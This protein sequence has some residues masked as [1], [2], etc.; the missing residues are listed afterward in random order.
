MS[1]RK[2]FL[3]LLALIAL[4]TPLAPLQTR[5][6][7]RRAAQPAV[8]VTPDSHRELLSTYCYTCHSSR[9]KSGGLALDSFDLQKAPENAEVW[10]KA[11][12]KLRGRLMPPPGNP[13]PPQKDIDAFITWMESTLDSGARGPWAGY[14]PI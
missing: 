13:Q 3:C 2:G 12:R 14:V 9:M 11:L 4:I 5:A 6:Q 1:R 7:T 8:A 10:E